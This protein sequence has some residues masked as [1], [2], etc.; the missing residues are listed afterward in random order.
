MAYAHHLFAPFS[1]KSEDATNN[2]Q[3]NLL[4]TRKKDEA[5]N[6]PYNYK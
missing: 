2:P 1:S 4:Y 5:F 3:F 6:S